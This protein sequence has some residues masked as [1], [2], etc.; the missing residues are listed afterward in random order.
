MTKAS[1]PL[2]PDDPQRL[3]GNSWR[4]RFAVGLGIVL[5]TYL[6]TA[7][8]AVPAYWRWYVSRHPQLE[9][10]PRITYAANGI[11]GDPLNV[12]LIGD[13]AELVAGMH[14]AKWTAADPLTLKSSLRIGIDSVL[15]RPDPDAPVSSLYLFGRKEDLAFEMQVGD[16]PRHRHHVRF[17]KTEVAGPDGRIVWIGSAAFDRGI[18]LSHETGQITHHIA[19]DIDAER[20]YVIKSLQDAQQL[21]EIYWINNFHK[22]R[23]GRNGGG[24]P[25]TTDGRLEVGIL[26]ADIQAKTK[27]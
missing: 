23:Q 9:E 21:K 8:A 13:E 15:R 20:D 10:I 22:E 11:P 26:N 16:N 17:W 7:Y 25:Y 5:A 2:L 3:R 6:L 18:G 19:A 4:K 24:D 14:E 12:A 27:P 1:A